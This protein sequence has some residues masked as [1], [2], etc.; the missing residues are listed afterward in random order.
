MTSLWLT[1]Q[2]IAWF[3]LEVLGVM[4]M[5]LISLGMNKRK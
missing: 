2:R 4:F 1:I 5:V 3:P